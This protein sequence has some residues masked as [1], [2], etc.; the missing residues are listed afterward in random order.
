MVSTRR[1]GSLS[2]NNPTTANGSSK[3]SP[4]SSEDK[5]PSPKRQK[6]SD[7]RPFIYPFRAIWRFLFQFWGFPFS[8]QLED[9]EK[10]AASAVGQTVAEDTSK[11]VLGDAAPI[12]GDAKVEASAAATAAPP[13]LAEG[14]SVLLLLVSN[15]PKSDFQ[16]C[17][18]VWMPFLRLNT[19]FAREANYFFFRME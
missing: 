9:V 13:P 5:P 4:S 16:F 15:F 2:G 3:R 10:P 1:S 14:L 7:Q 17:S 19:G 12:S 6:V 11:E 18:W 8:F